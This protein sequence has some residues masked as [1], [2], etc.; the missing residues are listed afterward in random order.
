M[1][2][3]RK[4]MTQVAI[5]MKSTTNGGNGGYMRRALMQKPKGGL[6][7]PMTATANKSIKAL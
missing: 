2:S 4:M 7:K 6:T 1:K 5:P 3:T